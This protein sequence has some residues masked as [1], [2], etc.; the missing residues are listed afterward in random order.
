MQGVQVHPGELAAHHPVHV[1][2]ILR[3][4]G[5]RE[6]GPVHCQALRAV[7]LLALGDDR[8]A[9]IYDRAKYI[10]GERL[11]VREVIYR[12]SRLPL[13]GVPLADPYAAPM[14]VKRDQPTPR[15]EEGWSQE[16]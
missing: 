3:A 11:Y 13:D 4:P 5:V 14:R 7:Q 10:E 9:I 2:T 12:H 8:A 16:I 6:R 1:G 15:R